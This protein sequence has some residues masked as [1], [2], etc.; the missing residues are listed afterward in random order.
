MEVLPSEERFVGTQKC[1][2]GP[3]FMANHGLNLRSFVKIKSHG[4]SVICQAWPRADLVEI[5]VQYDHMVVMDND[6]DAAYLCTSSISPQEIEYLGD[7]ASVKELSVSVVL[8]DL[9]LVKKYKGSIHEQA[10]LSK[11]VRHILKNIG[12]VKGCCVHCASLNLAK[13]YNVAYVIVKDFTSEANVGLLKSSSIIKI[14]NVISLERY[15]QKSGSRRVKLGGLNRPFDMLKE[16]IDL[17]FHHDAKLRHLGISCP[18]GVLL[19][20]PPGCGK[21]SLVKQIAIASDAHLIVVNSPE[22]FGSRPGES[23]ENLRL[24]FQMA[25]DMCEEGPC[26]LFIDEI[27]TLCPKH[28]KSGGNAESCLVAQLGSLMDSVTAVKGL[29]VV[30]ATNRPNQLDPSL[31]RPGR[32]DREVCFKHFLYFIY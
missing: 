4:K 20:G 31:R 5:F 29:L 7:G 2:L 27:D 1:C 30:A 6:V 24:K 19:Q 3:K 14:E 16:I 8:N 18:A 11:Y 32:F 23:E 17:P 28:G 9:K 25:S 22:I 13:L 26:I 21:T 12:I 15:E 10:N